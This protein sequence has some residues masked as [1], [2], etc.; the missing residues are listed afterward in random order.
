M[1]WQPE[2]RPGIP[3]SITK[4]ESEGSAALLVPLNLFALATRLFG[5]PALGFLG[6]AAGIFGLAALGL[7]GL[8]A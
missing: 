6:L 1:R 5:L 8:S 4:P 3:E 7:L 2:I